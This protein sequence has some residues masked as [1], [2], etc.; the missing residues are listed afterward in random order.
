MASAAC[1]D[2][3]DHL[4]DFD[5]YGRITASI[6]GAITRTD[7][8]HSRKYAWRV[9]MGLEPDK[10]PGKDALRGIEHEIDALSAIEIQTGEL[11]YEGRF[12]S[13]PTIDWLGSSP[14]GFIKS[15]MYNRLV[16]VEC[17]CPREFYPEIPRHYYEQL[18]T[19]MEC[20]DS[21]EGMFV[22][23]VSGKVRIDLVVRDADWWNQTYPVLKDFYEQY[24]MTATEPPRSPRRKKDGSD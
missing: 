14:D 9:V 20:L 5:R 21:P 1:G 3:S 12:V 24:V 19:Q 10:D 8:Y 17:K 11:V 6:V 23:W 16:P 18:Q 4:V 13:H 15:T 22:Q 2:M 7:P